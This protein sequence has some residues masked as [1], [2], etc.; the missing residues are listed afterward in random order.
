MTWFRKWRDP[1]L[2]G[3]QQV[4]QNIS[5][6]TIQVARSQSLSLPSIRCKHSHCIMPATATQGHAACG[7]TRHCY[8]STIQLAPRWMGWCDVGQFVVG[9]SLVGL[10]WSI[11]TTFAMVIMTVTKITD[12]HTVQ[13]EGQLNTLSVKCRFVWTFVNFI[14]FNSKLRTMQ[15]ALHFK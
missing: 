7:N 11:V 1:T 3:R 5:V 12:W 2:K 9:G 14:D 10:E 8:Q 13:P 4:S 15:L 6:L